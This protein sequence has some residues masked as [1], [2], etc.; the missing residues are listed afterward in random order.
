M[1]ILAISVWHDA[2]VAVLADGVLEGY[3]KEERY[4]GVKHDT[5]PFLAFDQALNNLQG[6]VDAVVMSGVTQNDP[7]DHA[8]E[9]LVNKRLGIT[10]N[11]YYLSAEHHLQHASLAFHRSGWDHAAVVVVDRMGSHPH[12]SPEHLRECETV[13]EMKL[14]DHIEHNT[15]LKHWWS[16]EPDR[17]HT[18]YSIVRVYETAGHAIG[19]N[20][21]DNGKVMGLSSWGTPNACT[22]QLFLGLGQPNDLLFGEGEGTQALRLGLEPVS[23]VTVN[24]YQPYA[25][26]AWAVQHQ[27]QE[28]LL[29][30]VETVHRCTGLTR[31]CVTG[32]Y[33]LNILANSYLVEKHPDWEF[34][35]EPLADDSG[36][37]IGAAVYLYSYLTRQSV[38]PIQDTFLHGVRHSLDDVTGVE[39]SV[40]NIVDL[41]LANNS[42]GVYQGLAEAGPRALGHRSILHS[43]FD[44][45]A[46]DHVN[47]I[48]RR[49]WYRPFAAMVL[50]EDANALFDMMGLTASP[51]MTNSFRV[52]EFAKD[53]IPG[54]VH[55]DGTCRIQTVNSND[56]V[57]HQ[58]LQAI[59]EQHGYG[60][61]LNTSM[62]LAGEP[63][64]ETPQQAL[65]IIE[66]SDLNYV[67]F[68]EIETLSSS[69]LDNIH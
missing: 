57:I 59:K 4:S 21:L 53:L 28:Q 69:T 54:V 13:F 51:N 49:E 56:G 37:S 61:L 42:V 24:N 26:Y 58:L 23:E 33:G 43:A 41:L 25:D 44:P 22:D 34:Y 30:L 35:F 52:R 6:S 45:H 12:P 15:Q 8:F 46:K 40:S 50:E 29:E 1:R 39:T 16:T 10:D 31:Y 65:S 19:V 27:T 47:N 11:I 60:V 62:N 18:Q 48:K 67:W 14:T 3:Y 5:A 55:V 7:L 20:K 36:N 63:L 32:G 66:R 64:V 68:P 38:A 2:S 17:G 9:R